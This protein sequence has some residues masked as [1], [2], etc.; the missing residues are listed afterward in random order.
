[1]VHEEE[2]EDPKADASVV[3]SAEEFPERKN[4][5]KPAG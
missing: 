5:P 3:V 4:K 1:M 2:N